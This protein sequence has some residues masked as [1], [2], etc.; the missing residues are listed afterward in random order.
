MHTQDFRLGHYGA[1][2]SGTYKVTQ[3]STTCGLSCL[4]SKADVSLVE[5][6]SK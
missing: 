4:C 2:N 3:T 1:A 5:L 6:L